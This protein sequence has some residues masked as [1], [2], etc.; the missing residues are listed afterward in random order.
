MTGYLV[1]L[2][3]MSVGGARNVK[4]EKIRNDIVDCTYAADGITNLTGWTLTDATGISADGTII[5]GDG[6]DPQGND[7]AWIADIPL[8]VAQPDH[9]TNT[10]GG[11][12]SAA[13]NWKPGVPTAALNAEIDAPG[14][15]SVAITST[16]IAYGLLLNDPNATVTDN[17]G[18]LGQLARHT[19]DEASEFVLLDR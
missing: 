19:V 13:A 11:N 10:R 8:G 5:V 17:S 2:R 12:W 6:I 14:M 18:P 1:A 3:W 4:P 16:A 7:E 15:Y 9:W